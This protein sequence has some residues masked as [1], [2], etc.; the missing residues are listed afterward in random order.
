MAENTTN[1]AQEVKSPEAAAT[2]PVSTEPKPPTE[3][4][5]KAMY[6]ALPDMF[7][8]AIDKV[9]AEIDSHNSKVAS[10][11]SAEAKDPKLIKAEIFE[12]NPGNNKKLATLRKEYLKLIEQ[13]EKLVSDA[14]KVIETDGLMPKEL[15]E[16]E[17]EKI[18][19]EV[20]ESTK[21][22]RD[23]VSALAKFEE[24][25]PMLK[26]KVIPLVN[27]I[28]TRR[29]AAKA[30]TTKSG[31]GP[32][33]IR[34]KRIEVNGVTQDDKGNKVFGLVNGEEKYTF[35]F[36]SAFLRK[37]HKGINWTANDLT[38]A[39]LK[40]LDEN[41]LPEVKEFSLP[42]TFKDENGNDQTVSYTVKAY[43]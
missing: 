40:G 18:K 23:Q 5:L 34:F 10:V 3:A 25:M 13:A 27:E 7:K 4:E 12:Q 8:E 36:A 6:D 33:R 29:G 16:A 11:L 21:G 15:T 39:Y 38:D 19:A 14:Y 42:Y 37:Q 20:T 28:K 32:K 1:T 17:L 31:E 30:G 43:R 2:T 9:N 24:M 26:G 35:T 22:L 41:N